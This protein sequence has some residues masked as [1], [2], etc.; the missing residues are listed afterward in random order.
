MTTLRVQYLGTYPPDYARHRIVQKGLA[1]LGVDIEEI[2]NHDVL[3]I[4]YFRLMREVRSA[5]ATSPIVIGE[6]GNYLLPVLIHAR[7][8][9]RT[10]VFDQFISLG[11]TA[12]DRHTDIRSSV[13]AAL[14]FVVDLCNARAASSVLFDTK[15]NRDYFVTRFRLDPSKAYVA[16]VGAETD[17]FRPRSVVKRRR[18]PVILFYG[19]FIPLHGIDVIVRAA[20]EVG[21]LFPSACFQIVGDGQTR[22]AIVRMV[23][24]MSLTNVDLSVRSVNYGDL[25]DLIA[26]SDICLGVFAHRSKTM[27]V[28]PNKVFQCAAMGVPVITAD[29]PAIRE[30]FSPR[31]V[32]VVPPGDHQRLA[33]EIVSL[34]SDSERRVQ[35]G[36]AGASAVH[37]RFNPVSIARQVLSALSPLDAE[38]GSGGEKPS[39]AFRKRSCG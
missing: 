11:D 1:A 30:G 25:P 31:E 2:R 22:A 10:V 34:L 28:I 27:R 13:R 36:A 39:L 18:G 17:V 32:V 7:S 3:P 4:R 12:A 6:F 24:R 26:G 23:A 21:R 38:A 14:G 20:R 19:T 8:L 29:T 5:P 35:V 15:A 9:K 16:Y 33:H 37:E